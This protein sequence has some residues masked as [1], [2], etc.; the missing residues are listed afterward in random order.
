M[1][2]TFFDQ[3]C[4]LS[5]SSGSRLQELPPIRLEYPTLC[6]ERNRLVIANQEVAFLSCQIVIHVLES[7]CDWERG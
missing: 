1:V 2:L 7:T 4:H 5:L 3:Q 6:V